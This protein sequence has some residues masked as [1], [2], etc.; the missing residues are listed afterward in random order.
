MKKSFLVMI[1]CSSWLW[2]ALESRDTDEESSSTFLPCLVWSRR[3]PVSR[4]R[5]GCGKRRRRRSLLLSSSLFGGKRQ[6]RMEAMSPDLFPLRFIWQFCY[7]GKDIQ[8]KMI[9]FRPE[10]LYTVLSI[11]KKLKLLY[12]LCLLTQQFLLF[13]STT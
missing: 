10:F 5:T 13:E 8:K 11:K 7:R 6:W 1:M 4:S 12:Q 3:R 9:V 2:D